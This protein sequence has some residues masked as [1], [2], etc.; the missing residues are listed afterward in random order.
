M[1][2]ELEVKFFNF[3]TNKIPTSKERLTTMPTPKEF[4]DRAQRQD[5]PNM[6]I[7]NM[8]HPAVQSSVTMVS[9]KYIQSLPET[10]I[11]P[12]VTISLK[13]MERIESRSDI[14]LQKYVPKGKRYHPDVGGSPFIPGSGR[15][16]PPVIA[17]DAIRACAEFCALKRCQGGDP[18][19]IKIYFRKM[20]GLPDNF[21]PEDYAP[22]IKP[23]RTKPWLRACKPTNYEVVV[24]PT[25]QSMITVNLG[26][27]RSIVAGNKLFIDW[28]LINVHLRQ[29]A[30]RVFFGEPGRIEELKKKD[31]TL[32][33]QLRYENFEIDDEILSIFN[34]NVDA[35]GLKL[36]PEEIKI[37]MTPQKKTPVLPL[38]GLIA[39]ALPDDAIEEMQKATEDKLIKIHEKPSMLSSYLDDLASTHDY[40]PFTIITGPKQTVHRELTL[41]QLMKWSIRNWILK[42]NANLQTMTKALA[43]Y[44]ILDQQ[45]AMQIL[46]DNFDWDFLDKVFIAWR[47]IRSDLSD[48]KVGAELKNFFFDSSVKKAKYFLDTLKTVFAKSMYKRCESFLEVCI[49]SYRSARVNFSCLTI[50]D[51]VNSID[52]PKDINLPKLKEIAYSKIS[53]MYKQKYI[54]KS[55]FY[56][57]QFKKYKEIDKREKG[58]RYQ[59]RSKIYPLL[60][61]SSRPWTI[62]EVFK[63]SMDK[64]VKKR[65]RYHLWWKTEREEKMD[66]QSR[67]KNFDGKTKTK[68]TEYYLE[69]VKLSELTMQD[70]ETYFTDEDVFSTKW[71][72]NKKFK[73]KQNFIRSQLHSNLT[74][75]TKDS[76]SF[77][78]GENMTYIIHDTINDDVETIGNDECEYQTESD[79]EIHAVAPQENEPL[80]TMQTPSLTFTNSPDVIQEKSPF[81]SDS[82]DFDDLLNDYNNEE[83]QYQQ[84][85]TIKDFLDSMFTS[86]HMTV[87]EEIATR[88]NYEFDLYGLNDMD[89][90]QQ[91]WD[92]NAEEVKKLSKIKWSEEKMAQLKKHEGIPQIEDIT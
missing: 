40:G 1:K 81:P 8:F 83:A 72:Q 25:Q 41:R 26:N 70:V 65:K 38:R 71:Y 34:P 73:K 67:L 54:A 9:E 79:D 60:G 50:A 11:I 3:N 27:T 90:L 35:T 28:D 69:C 36:T 16:I 43:Y 58:I 2:S 51:F 91:F 88:N 48:V 86:A 12:S 17:Q 59:M 75:K 20:W 80:I 4:W 63:D 92:N 32:K 37:L 15:S 21:D 85:V 78:K 74:A 55:R 66:L 42:N 76:F 56:M 31:V 46:L 64:Y 61:F 19:P 84:T 57:D 52:D 33:F 18:T 7:R 82:L 22:T 5:H 14:E 45:T 47:K 29:I 49:E 24:L 87:F 77:T 89:Q 30:T 23:E 62:A 68:F 39:Q 44:D 10:M 53:N 6:R 13:N